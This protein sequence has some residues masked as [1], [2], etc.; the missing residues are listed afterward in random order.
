MYKIDEHDSSC[1][2]IESFIWI[3]PLLRGHLS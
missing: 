3:E 1:P 2:I